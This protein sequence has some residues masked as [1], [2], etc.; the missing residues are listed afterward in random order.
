MKNLK[1]YFEKACAAGLIDHSLRVRQTD[2]GLHFYIHPAGADG[3]TEDYLLVG[4]SLVVPSDANGEVV[5]E[6]VPE[7]PRVT[8]VRC[9]CCG[10]W[11][12]VLTPEDFRV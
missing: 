9:S 1:A 4:N 8:E 6:F 3:D 11:N 12:K 2:Q 7:I 5:P 10:H